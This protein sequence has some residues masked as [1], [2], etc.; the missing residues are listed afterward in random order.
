MEEEEGAEVDMVIEA[1]AMTT[2]TEATVTEVTAAEAVVVEEVAEEEVVT[3]E[4]GTGT[5]QISSPSWNRI[6]EHPKKVRRTQVGRGLGIR[7]FSTFPI[8]KS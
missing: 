2:D 6:P 4:A 1:T 7:R 8:S 3:V 5:S